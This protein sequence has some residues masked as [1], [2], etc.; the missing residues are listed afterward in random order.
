MSLQGF[1]AWLAATP[2]SQ[3]LQTA[4][5]IIPAVQTVHILCIAVVI[6]AVLLVHLHT[7]GLAMRAQSSALLAARFLPGLW[8]ALILLLL[9]G[10]ILIVAE[11]ERS[12]PNY[13]FQVKMS[14][15]IVAITLT[16]LYQ[17]PLRKDPTY[18]EK[19]PARRTNSVAI[20]IVSLLAWV[21]IVFAGRWIA[22][23]IA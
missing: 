2:A 22:Y 6:S 10:S 9:S 15:L 14:L 18:W 11:P 4:E 7:L 5:W 1:C 3:F 17:V 20:A 12:L 13:M 21:G 16:L 19:T 23:A 8:W